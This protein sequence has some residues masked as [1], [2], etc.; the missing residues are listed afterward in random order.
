[1]IS[2]TQVT[3]NLGKNVRLPDGSIYRFTGATIRKNE[4]GT[5]FY[6]AEL[7]DLAALH[8]VRVCRL[9]EITPVE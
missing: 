9:E 5:V 1:M 7:Q 4:D 2:P 8:S 6:Q 3:A